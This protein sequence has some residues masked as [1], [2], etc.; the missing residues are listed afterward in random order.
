MLEGATSINTSDTGW[1]AKKV[2]LN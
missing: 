2:V 1:M